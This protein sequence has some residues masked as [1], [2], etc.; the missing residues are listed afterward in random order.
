MA[1]PR[2]VELKDA[3]SRDAEPRD[4]E[5]RGLRSASAT[6]LSI[7]RIED[8]KNIHLL[9]PCFA[10]IRAQAADARLVIAGEYTGSSAEQ[11]DLYRQRLDRIVREL[12]LEDSVSF[13]GPVE[14]EAKAAL[15]RR[16]ALLLNLSTDPGETF[17][18]N[19]IEA[20]VWGV[21]VVCSNWDGFQEVVGHGVDGFLAGCVWERELPLLR[22]E[23]A[24]EF[25]LLL[26]QNEPLRAE[27]SQCAKEAARSYDYRRISPS[28]AAAVEAASIERVEPVPD[29]WEIART[30]PIRLPRLYRVENLRQLPFGAQPLLAVAAGRSAEPVEEWMRKVKPLI[31][32]FAGG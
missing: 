20:K 19:L 25:A 4:A 7:G 24:A 27:F 22:W 10:A 21:P 32:H 2:G 6:I 31:G 8:V 13:A 23:Q 14:G 28:I 3:E 26:L 18:F 9:L 11:I 30:E 1:A 5:S 12:Q 16:S 17:G 29:A 15:F